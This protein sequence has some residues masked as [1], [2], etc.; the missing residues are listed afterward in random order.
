[1][2]VQPPSPEELLLALFED[3]QYVDGPAEADFADDADNDPDE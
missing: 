2:Q 3:I 1:M